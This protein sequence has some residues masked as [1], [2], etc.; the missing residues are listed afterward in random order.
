MTILVLG[1]YLTPHLPEGESFPERAA[2]FLADAHA[3]PVILDFTAPGCVADTLHLL[4]RPPVRLADYDLI[5]LPLGTVQPPDHWLG[6]FRRVWHLRGLARQLFGLLAAHRQRVL[7]I[8]PTPCLPVVAN[9][10]RRWAGYSLAALCRRHAFRVVDGFGAVPRREFVFAP[11][12]Q[13]L[14][15]LGHHYL[16]LGLIDALNREAVGSEAVAVT[17]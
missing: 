3:A 14:N 8:G 4:R 1:G 10:F 9:G 7:V 13:T 5:L 11:D 16:A 2:Q 6:G 17:H 12:G 15:N